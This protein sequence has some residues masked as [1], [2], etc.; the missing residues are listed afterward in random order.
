MTT[1]GMGDR[2]KAYEKAFDQHLSPGRIY[3]LR[4]D[5]HTFS[6]FTAPFIKPWDIRI[7][8][9][10]AKVCEDLM[11]QYHCLSAYT[12][13]DE[14]TLLFPAAELQEKLPFGGR[15]GKLNTLTAAYCSVRFCYHMSRQPFDAEL[16]PNIAQRILGHNAHFDCRLF[17]IPEEGE[18]LNNL[19]WRCRDIKR[20]SKANFSRKFF[21]DKQLHGLNS[22]EMIKKVE[23]E[24]GASW[25]HEPAWFRYGIV[26]KKNQF[27]KEAVD[28]NGKTVDA[29]RTRVVCRAT[30]L[31]WDPE[32]VALLLAKY[33]DSSLCG[34]TN[35]TFHVWGSIA[36]EVDQAQPKK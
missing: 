14:I 2:M 33:V 6:K 13:S 16:E 19:I 28:H 4:L 11:N 22:D 35:S 24:A 25:E 3:M 20:N 23:A 21:S 27:T 17:E 31:N 18:A 1:S 34:E 15:V 7:A 9:T 8:D 36:E 30:E 10:M 29:I 32:M 5:G 26:F 12:Q